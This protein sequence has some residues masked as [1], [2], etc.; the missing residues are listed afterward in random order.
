MHHRLVFEMADDEYAMTEKR[1]L[2]IC[3]ERGLYQTPYLNENLYF[4]CKG[5]RKIENL[6]KYTECKALWLQS[7]GLE[8]IENI[9]HMTHL[10]CLYLQENVIEHIENI[11]LPNLK[12]L[13]LSNNQIHCL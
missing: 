13:N 4:H 9:E 5:F 6:D 3:K 12:Q 8:K 10:T 2:Q 7:N 1:L 11:N